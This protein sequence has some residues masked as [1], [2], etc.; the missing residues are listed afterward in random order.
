MAT[1]LS[2]LFGT[3]SRSSGAS[4]RPARSSFRPQ[5][6]AL[7]ERQLMTTSTVAVLSPVTDMTQWAKTLNAAHAGPTQLYLNFDGYSAKSWSAFQPENGHTLEQDIQEIL[8]R[9]SEYFAPFD[10][11]VQRLTGDGNYDHGTSIPGN[12]TIFVWG[13]PN[14]GTQPSGS[15]QADYAYSSN[16]TYIPDS[17]PSH[18]AQVQAGGQSNSFIAWAIAHEAGHTF[19]LAH[20]R[21]DGLTDPANLG[22]ALTGDEMSYSLTNPVYPSYF[23]NK[24][25]TIT[26]WNNGAT[27]DTTIQPYSY[28]GLPPYYWS[29]V[30]I[31]TQNSYTY[32]QYVLGGGGQPGSHAFEAIDPS[33]SNTARL[34]VLFSQASGHGSIGYTGDY[35]V[36]PM[37]QPSA[38]TYQLSVQPAAGS[39]VVPVLMLFDQGGSLVQYTH[40]GTITTSVNGGQT[41]HAVVGA[42]NDASTGSFNLQVN[43]L[44][45]NLA[46]KT[47]WFNNYYSPYQNVGKLQ[48]QG[49][50]VYTG[51][52]YGTYTNYEGVPISVTGWITG[53][54]ANSSGATTSN[55]YFQGTLGP[56]FTFF[57]GTLSGSGSMM[58]GLDTDYLWNGSYWGVIDQFYMDAHDAFLNQWGYLG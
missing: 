53:T 52:F 57:N 28:T 21:T 49:E 17:A 58:T 6:E 19:G 34:P 30:A 37:S 50:N 23:A 24:Q 20:V 39:S 16:P 12:S 29:S 1:F 3:R 45:A 18:V 44:P 48:V 54:T 56:W 32:L 27:P 40:G 47:F 31:T 55:I 36:Y 13:N 43:P 11:E 5:F 15:S 10:V 25:N 35:E 14:V 46:G 22:A 38:R 8:F 41:Y 26:N 9:T 51:W 4:Q 7:E 42:L 33:L 2:K